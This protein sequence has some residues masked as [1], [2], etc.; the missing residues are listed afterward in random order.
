MDDLL[1]VNNKYFEKDVFS[2]YPKELKLTETSKSNRG[3]SYFD[4][5]LVHNEG[6]INCRV[7]DKRDYFNF[8]IVNYPF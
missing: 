6:E 1:S 5:L 8:D 7:Y 2:N 4:L 3:C